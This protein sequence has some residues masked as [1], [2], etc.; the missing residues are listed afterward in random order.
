M[1]RLRDWDS[2]ARTTFIGL[3]LTLE[4]IEGTMR[5]GR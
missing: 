2:D 4:K 5:E 1:A 3:P